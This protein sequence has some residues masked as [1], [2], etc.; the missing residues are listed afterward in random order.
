M[1]DAP[2]V[3]FGSCSK[4]STRAVCLDQGDTRVSLSQEGWGSPAQFS[5]GWRACSPESPDWGGR[6]QHTWYPPRGQGTSRS[7]WGSSALPSTTQ[8]PPRG[9]GTSGSP[10]GSSGHLST[11]PGPLIARGVQ[12]SCGPGCSPGKLEVDPCVPEPAASP[13]QAPP[14]S[15]F[16]PPER[17][18]R[19][20]DPDDKQGRA[21]H[22]LL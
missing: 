9:Q 8:Y 11:I 1:A 10:R 5:R 21:S 12:G 22:R 6:P 15:C 20:A 17:R 13:L 2:S 16:R 14:H 19:E 3:L 4:L 7:S 18:E